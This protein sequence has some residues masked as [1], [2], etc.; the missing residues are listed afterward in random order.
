MCLGRLSDQKQMQTYVVTTD[1]QPIDRKTVIPAGSSKLKIPSR[2]QMRDTR[3][4]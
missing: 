1:P 3:L 2:H 4:S